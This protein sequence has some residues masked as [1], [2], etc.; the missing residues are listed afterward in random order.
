MQDTVMT[1]DELANGEDTKKAGEAQRCGV[2]QQ[3]C[4]TLGVCSPVHARCSQLST[5]S[6]PTRSLVRCASWRLTATP[7][8]PPFCAVVP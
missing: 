5:A 8:A 2:R 6:M 1:L 7:S 3:G 4:L